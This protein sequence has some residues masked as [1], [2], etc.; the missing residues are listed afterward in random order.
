MRLDRFLSNLKQGSRQ[1][2]RFWLAAGR[3]RIDGQVIRNGEHPIRRD[4]LI[5]LNDQCMQSPKPA[6]YFML[7]KPAGYLSAT[8]DPQHPTVLELLTETDL[9]GLHIAGRLDR[10]STGL[11]LITDDG[12]WSRRLTEPGKNIGKQYLVTT[13]DPIHPDTAARFCEGIYFDYE[14]ITTLPAELEQLGTRQVRLRL[15]EGRYHQI[16]RMFGRFR[17]K[18][19]TLHRES[20]GR[21]ELD[22]ALAPGQYRELTQTEVDSVWQGT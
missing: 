18:V 14:G 19:V 2:A 6:R 22:S 21:I 3:V 9:T 13:E 17:N 7:N 8:R 4:Q 11:L 20:M 10:S 15:Y 1:K 5:E 12:H 16:K